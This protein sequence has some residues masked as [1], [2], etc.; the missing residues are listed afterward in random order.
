M[1]LLS[2]AVTNPFTRSVSSRHV[3]RHA[4]RFGQV[5][6]LVWTSACNPGEL[7][8]TEYTPE[9]VRK[10]CWVR[11]PT[12]VMIAALVMQS[13]IVVTVLPATQ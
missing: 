12:V 2:S 7:Q 1:W 3:T 5:L 13:I 9:P 4:F 11:L 6:W 8:H 10:L